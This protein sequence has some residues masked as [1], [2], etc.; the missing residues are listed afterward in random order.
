[1]QKCALKMLPNNFSS[2]K[3]TLIKIVIIFFPIFNLLRH[4]HSINNSYF[5]LP[6]WRRQS[7]QI[8]KYAL[9]VQNIAPKNY[10][11]SAHFLLSR[12]LYTRT[13]IGVYTHMY[14][15]TYACAYKI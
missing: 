6:T 12:A 13:R 10:I 4:T 5:L 7:M 8:I 3:K 15:L 1:M 2:L 11:F 9:I 14:M